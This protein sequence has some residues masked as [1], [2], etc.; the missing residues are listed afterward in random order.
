MNI[1]HY[2]RNRKSAQTADWQG[3]SGIF[4]HLSNPHLHMQDVLGLK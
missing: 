4:K 2:N 3:F 1:A